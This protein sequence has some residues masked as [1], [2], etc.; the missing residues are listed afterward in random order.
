MSGYRH[1]LTGNNLLDYTQRKYKGHRAI[2]NFVITDLH[3]EYDAHCIIALPGSSASGDFLG[4]I[5]KSPFSML[6][7]LDPSKSIASTALNSSSNHTLF[8]L[9]H[10]LMQ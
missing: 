4:N 3:K 8:K 1:G 10:C 6:A 5:F 9:M 7:H 2:P